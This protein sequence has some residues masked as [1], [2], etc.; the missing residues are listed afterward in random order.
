MPSDTHPVLDAPCGVTLTSDGSASLVAEIHGRWSYDGA[1]PDPEDLLQR[2]DGSTGPHR[3]LLR[4]GDLSGWDSSL[5]A[6]LYVLKQGCA[7]RGVALVREGFPD[8][9]ERLLALAAAGDATPG[10]HP[11]GTPPGL[12]NRVGDCLLEGVAGAAAL[13]GFVGDIALALVHVGRGRARIRWADLLHHFRDAGAGALPIVSLISL[14]TGLIMAFVGAVQLR[15]FGAQI[16]VANLVGLAMAREMAPMMTAVV[17]AG[18]TGAAYAAQLGTMGLSEE[19][20]ALR[21]LGVSPAAFL[22][23]PRFLALVLMMPLLCLYA[24]VMGILGGLLIGLLDMDLSPALYI[25]QTRAAVGLGDFAVGVAKSVVF[26]AVVAVAGCLRGLQ[27]ARS[28]SGVGDAAT[29][30]VVVS[31]VWIIVFDAIITVL[32]DAL[33]I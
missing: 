20:D 28:A 13:V 7:A 2:L 3:L 25:E 19:I 31:I 1:L 17:M 33:G 5:L 22:V 29:S 14:L 4:A 6:Y 11:S 10:T 12:L 8:G 24:D 32:C 23:L 15:M 21:T 9:V 30:A 16:Y 26:A 18:R 27:A